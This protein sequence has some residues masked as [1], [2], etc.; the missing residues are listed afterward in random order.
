MKLCGFEV[1]PREPLFLI[2]GPDSLESE[3]LAL[4]VAGHLAE[5]CR[6]LPPDRF[7]PGCG[8]VGPAGE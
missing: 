1:G 2:A 7:H 5:V 3:E 8:G 4:E 6:S